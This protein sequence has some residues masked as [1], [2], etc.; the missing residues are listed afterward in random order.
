VL[1]LPRF[2]VRELGCD[3]R[4]GM[5]ALDWLSTPTQRL[6]ELTAGAVF[7]DPS[8]DLTHARAA[9]AWYPH[10]VWL[11]VI[12]RQWQRIAQ[13]EAFVG[14]CAES[15]DEIG[16][17]VVTARLVRDLMRLC[18]LFERR[19]APYGKWL[20]SAFERLS[21][22]SDLAD[23]LEHALAASDYNVREDALAG[24][25]ESVAM[26]HNSL[27]ITPLVD[28]RVRP[29]NGRPYL[30]L[31]AGRFADATLGAIDP[32]V[33]ASVTHM[34]GS[35]DQVVDNTGTLGSPADCRRV[36]GAYMVRG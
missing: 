20:G 2:L 29:Y 28:A 23:S 7:E 26:L 1:S 10:D 15:G 22:A 16:S 31:H 6:L 9:L 25:Y 27:A 18:F 36:L 11:F 34:P 5:S 12:A 17:R 13:E 24:A 3:P 8:G 33:L 35:I 32:A 21:C 19:Y 14:R 4:S 30:V